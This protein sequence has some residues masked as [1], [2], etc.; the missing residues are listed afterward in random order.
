MVKGGFQ[1]HNGVYYSSEHSSLLLLLTHPM[2]LSKTHR[3]RVTC[4]LKI[5]ISAVV[6]QPPLYRSS[7]SNII[8]LDS[9]LVGL[10]T[11]VPL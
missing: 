4:L 8:A 9:F 3:L 1:I 6:E 7:L 10:T 5:I 2:E 11:T